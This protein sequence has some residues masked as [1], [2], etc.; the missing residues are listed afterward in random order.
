M[1]DARPG[2]VLTTEHPGYD[3]LMPNIEGCISYDLSVLASPLR[4]LPCNVQRFYFPE[5]KPFELAAGRRSEPSPAV[6]ERG[7]LVRHGLSAGHG[8]HL[9]RE[10][11]RAAGRDCEPLVPTLVRY[12]YANRFHGGGRTITMLYNATGR[13]LNAALLEVPPAAGRHAVD[14][15]GCREFICRAHGSSAVAEGFLGRGNVACL[16]CLPALLAVRRDDDGINVRLESPQPDGEMRLCD[17]GGKILW[18][19]PCGKELVRRIPSSNLPTR[20]APACLKLL[21]G[22]QLV[23]MAPLP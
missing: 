7:G 23:D 9:A 15:L 1:D 20:A 21:S 19:S 18:S 16:A 5:C 3:F 17:R 11:R 22:G 10:R 4:P 2:S 6:L 8:R 13:S 14:L 12:V